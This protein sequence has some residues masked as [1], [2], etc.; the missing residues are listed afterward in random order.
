[1]EMYSSEI[2]TIASDSRES[3]WS[4]NKLNIELTLWENKKIKIV[5]YEGKGDKM[6]ERS[7][8]VDYVVDSIPIKELIAL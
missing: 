3:V 1:M 4:Y 7:N 8:Y 6:I 5:N 2:R